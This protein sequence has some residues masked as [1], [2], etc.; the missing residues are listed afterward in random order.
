VSVATVDASSRETVHALVETATE[1]G[2]VTGVA[3]P[4]AGSP[5]V[6]GLLGGDL[7]GFPNGRRVFDDVVAIELRAI[8][9]VGPRRRRHAVPGP[10]P[11]PGPAPQ[12]LRRARRRVTTADSLVVDIGGDTGVLIVYA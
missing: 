4:P 2:E 11:L 10:V 12:R 3:I 6:F 9:G 7:A 8:A 5:S 1:L